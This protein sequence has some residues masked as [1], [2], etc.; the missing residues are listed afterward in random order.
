MPMQVQS[1]NETKKGF[2]KPLTSKRPTQSTKE[3]LK[4][5]SQ[6]RISHLLKTFES[7]EFDGEAENVEELIL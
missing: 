7:V 6:E 3:T 1:R 4:S 5:N 2:Q